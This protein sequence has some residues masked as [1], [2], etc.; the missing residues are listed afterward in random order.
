M[1]SQ[2][3]IE[4]GVNNEFMIEVY[5]QVLNLTHFS[6]ETLLLLEKYDKATSEKEVQEGLL[7]IL[8]YVC[9]VCVSNFSHLMPSN[10]IIY[11]YV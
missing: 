2:M 3:L 4:N 7:G 10:F 6:F 5:Q 1:L 9:T 8:W 11:M